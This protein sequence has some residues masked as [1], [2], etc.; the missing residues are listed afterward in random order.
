[1]PAGS[2]TKDRVTNCKIFAASGTA[3]TI[4]NCG[5]DRGKIGVACRNSR[6]EI[7]PSVVDL[8]SEQ[9]QETTVG[10]YFVA[11]YPP[12]SFWSTDRRD[13]P[14]AALASK[15]VEDAPLGVYVHIP[16]CRKRCHFCYFRVYTGDDA[17]HDRVSQYVDAV[18]REVP[19]LLDVRDEMVPRRKRRRKYLLP[20]MQSVQRM[21]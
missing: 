11:N 13:E 9:P 18:L 5:Q 19:G 15:P 7:V 6:G 14:I 2:G 21:P 12:F 16:F 17:K 8:P 3:R 4:E 1:M 20:P 10:N